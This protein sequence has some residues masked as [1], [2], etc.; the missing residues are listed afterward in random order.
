[1]NGFEYG[2][3]VFVKEDKERAYKLFE[4]SSLMMYSETYFWPL[5]NLCESFWLN[6]NSTK[7]LQRPREEIS[8]ELKA[9]IDFLKDDRKV[10]KI[11]ESEIKVQCSR[12]EKILSHI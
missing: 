7:Y 4:Y 9:A 8:K 5:I 12:L 2:G 1:M 3:E 10:K 6:E 11:K